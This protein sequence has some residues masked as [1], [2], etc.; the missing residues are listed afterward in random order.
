MGFDLFNC[1]LKIRESIG[2]P[3]P[4]VGAHSMK[5]CKIGM[6]CAIQMGEKGEGS[7]VLMGSSE[8]IIKGVSTS[9]WSK[10]CKLYLLVF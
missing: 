5:Q 4:K 2:T 3:T 9:I 7:W 8:T 10:P 1:S 6:E